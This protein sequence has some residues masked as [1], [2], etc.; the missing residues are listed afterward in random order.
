MENPNSVCFIS[1]I[2][3]I[4]DIEN[5]QNIQQVKIEG[6]SSIIQKNIHKEGDLILCITTDAVI[7]EELA[8]KWSVNSYLRKGNRVRTIKLKGVYSECILIPTLDIPGYS[9]KLRE[10]IDG[11]DCMKILNITKYEPPVIEEKLPNGKKVKYSQNS[12]FH[13][14]YKFPNLKN[15]PKMFT[16]E[17]DIVITRKIHGTN[18]RYGIVKKNKLSIIN[19][20]KKLFGNK[21][22]QYEFVYGSH[23]IQ[24]ISNTKG[25]YNTNVWDT[26][27]K[28]YNIEKK[29]WKYFKENITLMDNLIIYGEIYG[30]GIQGEKYNYGLKDS[31]ALK[32]FDVEIDSKYQSQINKELFFIDLDLP[33]VEKLYWGKYN[34]SKR[35]LFVNNQFIDNTN[36]PHEGIVISSMDGNRNK[37]AKFINP[38]YHTFAEKHLIPD[39]H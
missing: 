5:A 15:T 4:N 27:N 6:W 35:D 3:K 28:Q 24:K 9:S 29:L 10:L 30:A 22:I 7:P 39:S 21:W 16:E 36:T 23:N 20:I 1:K 12:N 34:D 18:A 11:T 2:L 13:I 25:Y 17:D 19:R 32:C 14:Y 31:I 33:I 38:E 8:I 26:I 37:I